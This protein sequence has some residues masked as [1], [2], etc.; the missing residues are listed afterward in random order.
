MMPGGSDHRGCSSSDIQQRGGRGPIRPI[1]R[2]MEISLRTDRPEQTE[3]TVCGETRHEAAEKLALEQSGAGFLS[4]IL[5]IQDHENGRGQEFVYFAVLY[6]RNSAPLFLEQKRL[7]QGASRLTALKRGRKSNSETA[8]ERTDPEQ[9]QMP[10][11][12]RSP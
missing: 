9:R 2:G 8:K 4:A 3:E 10:Y 7:L 6:P 11:S 1:R 12:A 5:G